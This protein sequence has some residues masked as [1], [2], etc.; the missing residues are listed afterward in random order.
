MKY[1]RSGSTMKAL[2]IGAAIAII[3]FALPGCKKSLTDGIVFAVGTSSYKYTALVQVR[4]ATNSNIAPGNLSVKVTGPDAG[5]VY[6]LLTGKKNLTINLDGTVQM[7]ISPNKP[8]SGP[9]TFNLSVNAPGYLPYA[10][11]VTINPADSAQVIKVALRTPSGSVPVSSTPGVAQ[12]KL[13]NGAL[14]Q[15]TVVKIGADN[16]LHT[17]V[18]PAQQTNSLKLHIMD[19]GSTP[20]DQVTY[21]D[22]GLTSIVLPKGTTFHYWELKPTGV[23]ITDTV[24]VPHTTTTTTAVTG[25]VTGSITSYKTYYTKEAYTYPE[26]AWN[27]VALAGSAASTD[28]IAAVVNYASAGNDISTILN[29]STDQEPTIH[30]TIGNQDVLQD[31]LLFTTIVSKRMTGNPVFYKIHHTTKKTWYDFTT[32]TQHTNET[33]P[34]YIVYDQEVMPDETAKWFTSFAIDPTKLNPNTGATVKDGDLVE[35]GIDENQNTITQTVKK[36]A[37]G[38]LR[39]Q[40]LS[41]DA[42]FF[43]KAPNIQSFNYTV[44]PGGAQVNDPENALCYMSILGGSYFF[45]FNAGDYGQYHIQGKIASKYAINTT[46]TA[47]TY[48]WGKEMSAQNMGL[49]ATIS[50]FNFAPPY[51]T[52]FLK[53]YG[54]VDATLR[55]VIT[56]SAPRP[57]KNYAALTYTINADTNYGSGIINLRNG[58]WATNNF[59]LSTKITGASYVNGYY[60]N[61]SYQLTASPHN[62]IYFIAPKLK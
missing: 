60:L 16:I 29:Y 48:Y 5:Q 37:N 25:I 23:I 45:Y 1:S 13:V 12:F 41:Y 44:N 2:S 32:H 20:A 14:A 7:V 10:Q 11:P 52:L 43:Y 55:E 57:G 24:L 50:P 39:V 28:S 47:T 40:M 31:E 42:G 8:V 33:V 3:C 17:T 30:T 6:D 56:E 27:K 22:D 62:D 26:T 53:V 54:T 49:S 19:D 58:E 4:D 21:Y 9:I 46:A 38:Q 51:P 34:A 35:I 59:P 15:Q 36:V 61:M 18:A